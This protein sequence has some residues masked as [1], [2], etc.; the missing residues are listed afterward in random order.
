MSQAVVTLL[1]VFLGAVLTLGASLL[2]QRQRD[3]ARMFVAARVLL[4]TVYR[5]ISVSGES[6]ARGR[7]TFSSDL[8]RR[9]V[10]DWPEQ[11][12]VLAERLDDDE[13]S[14]IQDA[15]AALADLEELRSGA[16][17][18][19]AALDEDTRSQLVA[20]RARLIGGD[21]LTD[22]L[23]PPAILG[24]YTDEPS[25][26]ARAADRARDLVAATIHFARRNR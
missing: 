1:A 25:I 9:L 17:D 8:I 24:R 19:D 5:G 11:R 14:V 26:R 18:A 21:P 4:F 15:F 22:P 2:L 23:S 6:L 13:W 7:Y 20:C 10:A 16:A 3:E 12:P